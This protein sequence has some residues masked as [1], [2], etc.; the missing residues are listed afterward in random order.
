M[1]CGLSMNQT[2]TIVSGLPRSGT[3]L[4]MQMLDIGGMKVM[5]D[6]IRVADEDN[7]KGYYEFEKVKKIGEDPSWLKDMR[8]KAFKM[9]SMLLYDLPVNEK[10]K[11]IFMRRHMD[12]ILT[13]QNKMLERLGRD[14]NPDDEMG[15]LFAKHL[16][17][18]FKWLDM[19]KNFKVLYVS[20]ND[21]VEDSLKEI[22]MVVGFLGIKL[23]VEKMSSVMD[24]ALYRNRGD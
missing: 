24:R 7:P 16:D 19:Q 11:V 5:T 8:G 2:I 3:S 12:E 6:N 18:T 23:D 22:E 15:K 14:L 10:Y 9:V 13:S 20:Y 21:L 17:K 1:I 4:M